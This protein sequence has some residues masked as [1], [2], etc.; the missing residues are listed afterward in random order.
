MKRAAVSFIAA[1]AYFNDVSGGRIINH[2]FDAR[3]LDFSY[4]TEKYQPVPDR[5]N[6]PG[7][8]PLP[9]TS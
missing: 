7:P 2:R 8:R 4:L 5:I 9:P 6:L 1:A 3:K